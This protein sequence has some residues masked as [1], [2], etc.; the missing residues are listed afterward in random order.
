MEPAILAGDQVVMIPLRSGGPAIGDVVIYRVWDSAFPDLIMGRVVALGGDSIRVEN[1]LATVNGQLEDPEELNFEPLSGPPVEPPGASHL[2]PLVL[3][4][5]HVFVMGD[6]RFVS[7]DSRYR[8]PV[9]MRDILGRLVRI[10]FSTN[11]YR[12]E[13]RW[14]RVGRPLH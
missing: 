7:Y 6:R 14:E 11:P 9:P 8:G 3:P 5:D 12:F 2:G 10:Y 4:V 13:P 1:G